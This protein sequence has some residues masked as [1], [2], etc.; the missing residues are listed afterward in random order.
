MAKGDAGICN[1]CILLIFY[2]ISTEA[3]L[4]A[5][6]SLL[7]KLTN[8]IQ[9]VTSTMQTCTQH[10]FYHHG[11]PSEHKQY[12]QRNTDTVTARQLTNDISIFIYL[13]FCC[14]T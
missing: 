7:N 8:L 10:Y 11:Q 5:A 1:R 2:N 14:R 13:P 12:N 9:I 6:G 4:L 3:A